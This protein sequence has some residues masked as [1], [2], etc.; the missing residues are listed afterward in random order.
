MTKLIKTQPLGRRVCVGY[1]VAFSNMCIALARLL[2][3]FD[4][5]PVPGALPDLSRPLRG[6]IERAAFQV[7]IKVRS[8]AHRQLIER[9]CSPAAQNV[10]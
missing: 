1:N 6:T 7:R 2:Y 10:H 9:E 8:Q 3:C 4:Y 5:E